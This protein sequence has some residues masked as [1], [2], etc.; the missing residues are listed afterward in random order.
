MAKIPA[1]AKKIDNK[2][3]PFEK[4]NKKFS[5]VKLLPEVLQTDN[6]K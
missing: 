5:N 3:I 4:P 1:K 2:T 6:N